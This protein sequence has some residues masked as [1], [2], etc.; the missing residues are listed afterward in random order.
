VAA[1]ET[2][3]E[4]DLFDLISRAGGRLR[5]GLGVGELS[6]AE[7]EGVRASL[8]SSAEA[9]RLYAEGIAKLRLFDPLGARELLEKAVAIEPTFALAHAALARAWSSLGYDAKATEAAQQA[10]RLS[11]ILGREDR[12]AVEALYWETA[13]RWDKSIEILGTLRSTFPDNIEYGLRLASAMYRSGKEQDALT[14]A[15][16]LHTLRPPA[17]DDPRIDLVE[18]T[19]GAGQE[20]RLEA[21]RSAIG[22]AKILGS[23]LLL[24]H[25]RSAEARA[26]VA[27]DRFAEAEASYDEALRLFA[28]AGDRPDVA[29]TQMWYSGLYRRQGSEVKALDLLQRSLTTYRETGNKH[30]T[31]FTQN[32]IGMI[33][34]ERGDLKG[35]R[36]A[37]EE[38]AMLFREVAAPVGESTAVGNLGAV[39]RYQGDLVGARRSYEEAFAIERRLGRQEGVAWAQSAVA[40]VLYLQ[41]RLEEARRMYDESTA[42][43]RQTGE[44]YCEYEEPGGVGE[45]QKSQGDLAGAR[46]TYEVLLNVKS[47]AITEDTR[48]GARLALARLSLEENRS[49]EAEKVARAAIAFYAKSEAIHG[50]A[51]ASGVLA[52]ALLGNGRASEALAISRRAADLAARAG[53]KETQLSLS[54]PLSRALAARGETEEAERR[55][56]DA[57]QEAKRLG[58]LGLEFETRLALG[59]IEK[60]S[61]KAADWDARLEA[62]ERDAGSKG[63]VLIARKAAS[64]RT[65]S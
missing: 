36:E 52:E 64:A 43:C 30:G 60:K 27:L 57:L 35:A 20:R 65:W 23:R 5:A 3:T 22:K 46:K 21:A 25:A 10:L 24:A 19:I 61:G 54:I 17:G 40:A 18:A 49:N 31:A 39:A 16:S 1:S 41:G 8:P 50:E 15:R 44:A 53:V 2:G 62:L 9:A 14:L 13:K 48:V 63:F 51:V 42:S 6:S 59:E 4:S 45:V 11:S 26:L 32:D 47:N 56:Q 55:L 28:E 37:L 12:L 38:S 29:K 58:Y 34:K 33:L 7:M